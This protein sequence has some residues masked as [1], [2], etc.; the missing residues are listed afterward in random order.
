MVLADRQEVAT[1]GQH[2][3]EVK[4]V[5]RF[6]AVYQLELKGKQA[7]DTS[8]EVVVRAEYN[9]GTLDTEYKMFTLRAGLLPN[10]ST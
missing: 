9:P 1:I 5:D 10:N 2:N 8:G 4:L 7:G 6:A 3:M